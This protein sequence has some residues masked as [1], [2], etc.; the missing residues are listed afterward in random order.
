[1]FINSH[2]IVDMDYIYLQFLIII[3]KL[4]IEVVFGMMYMRFFEFFKV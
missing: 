4:V 2:T 1:M 3:Q